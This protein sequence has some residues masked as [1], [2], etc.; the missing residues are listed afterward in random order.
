MEGYSFNNLLSMG[1]V[2][3]S[4]FSVR[5]LKDSPA[6]VR[7]FAQHRYNN[8]NPSTMKTAFHTL[9]VAALALMISGGFSA[10]AQVP[11]TISYQGR[12]QVGGTS[13]TGT[14]QFK[15]AL[16]D[17]GSNT[18]RQAT[19]TA[20]VTGG[21]LTAINVVNG[22]AGYT[23]PPAVTITD[24][25]GSGAVATGQVSGGRVTSITVQN[26][27]TGYSA[28]PVVGIA[29]PPPNLA[30]RTFWSNDG[31]SAAGSEP[32]GA[33]P[34]TVAQGLFTVL[35]GD[36]NLPNMLLIPASVFTNGGVHLRLWF[37]DGA[38][39]F[40]QLSPDLPVTSVG[41][42]LL[43]ASVLN[44]SV[45][46]GG[47]A[48]GSVT[49]PK[50][51]NGVVTSEK[52]ANGSIELADF[53]SATLASFWR[54]AGNNGT[55]PGTHFL[56]TTDNRV[57][58]VKVNG[59]RALRLEPT[60]TNGSVNVIGGSSGNHVAPGVVGATIAGG[61]SLDYFGNLNWSNT[62]Q[63]HFG[64]ISG[65]AENT[66]GTNALG[67]TIGGG[68]ENTIWTNAGSATI[69]GGFGNDILAGLS[70]IGGGDR[71]G[72]QAGAGEST[73]GG[74]IFNE[75]QNG[76]FQSTIGGG[77]GNI[78]QGSARATIGGGWRNVIGPNGSYAVIPGGVENQASGLYSF[79]AGYL[80][81][82]R[83]SGAFVW[84]DSTGVEFASTG[85]NQFLIRAAGGVGIGITN[86]VAPLHLRGAAQTM[87]V[88]DS[89][90]TMG[91]WLGI[92]NLSGGQRW[93]IISTG[94]GN[95]EGA[96]RLLFFTS[97]S[98]DTKMRLEPNGNLVID[99]SLSELSDR[100]RKE[101]FDAVDPQTVLEK[102][103]G[104]PIA[105]WNYRDDPGTTHLGPVA[106]D[107]HAAFGLGAD[108]KRIA[109]MD[110]SGV[111][112]AA[113]QGLNQKM[114]EKDARIAELEHRLE[115]L[116]RL[117]NHENGAA[118]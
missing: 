91:T 101:N 98:N 78:I 109:T 8:S 45:N 43:A 115:K 69:G 35:M 94:N 77:S 10:V 99:G 110:A 37:N 46:T 70:T 24:T 26:A 33:V 107:F 103:A 42:A 62:V 108:D 68:T 53:S 11:G 9:F 38:Q 88:I 90:H 92:G 93:S 16:V 83:H 56:G 57:L 5:F 86:P 82:A 40:T 31:T 55:T 64:T 20:S 18:V 117:L 25:T 14:G 79:A 76:S 6:V 28:S 12:V 95:G 7:F 61:G 27:G 47:L 85:N 32:S 58:E 87:A 67:G 75:I 89:S 34:V 71:N 97:Q 44:D 23:T 73:I 4:R 50:L 106:Q 102:V 15:F 3:A 118:R 21:F 80:A 105:R 41:Y 29:P 17:G 63:S 54:T 113:V 36:T 30:F 39:G 66:I 112:L 84:A 114:K 111:A 49:T 19:A 13:F 74:G 65:G 2:L 60:A 81:R 52:I 51:A 116:E 104:L 96:G 100:N 1:A 72:I 59:A 48:N 22:G